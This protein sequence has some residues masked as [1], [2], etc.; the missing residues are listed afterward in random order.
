M[1]VSGNRASS[2][3]S[4]KASKR[5]RRGI[6]LTVI[7]LA[8]AVLLVDQVTKRWAISA[9]SGGRTKPLLGDLLRFRLLYNPG[10][11]FSMGTAFTWVFTIVAAAAVVA[12][13]VI[14]WRTRSRLW[15]FGLGLALGGATSHLLDRLFR[16]PGFARGRVVD[17]IDYSGVFV[18]NIADIAI[19]GGMALL[20]VTYLAGVPVNPRNRR[21]APVKWPEPAEPTTGTL[22]MAEPETPKTEA[23]RLDAWP[24]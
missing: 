24:L 8:V 3:V 2:T 10:A 23:E 19:V 11:A 13:A 18:G 5:H 12:I 16:D 14:A 9:L 15:A 21:P 22:L 4:K 1:S 20:A 7:G 17:F 6:R